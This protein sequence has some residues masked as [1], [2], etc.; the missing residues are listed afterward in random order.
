MGCLCA[1]IGEF[2]LVEELVDWGDCW[3]CIDQVYRVD[4]VG[5]RQV[6]WCL[7]WVGLLDFLDDYGLVGD[8]SDEYF[9]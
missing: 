6:D 8:V 9:F 5:N 7:V 2:C 4:E 1:D 3:I